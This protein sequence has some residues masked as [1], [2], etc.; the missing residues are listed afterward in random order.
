MSKKKMAKDD[1]FTFTVGGVTRPMRR[2]TE[3]EWDAFAARH[4]AA[5]KPAAKK[6]VEVDPNVVY[7]VSVVFVDD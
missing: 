2:I 7:T 5:P 4:S 6:P 3:A 1:E